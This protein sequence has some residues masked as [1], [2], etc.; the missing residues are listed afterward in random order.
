MRNDDI[1]QTI[2]D[3]HGARRVDN[4]NW[5]GDRTGA[6]FGCMDWQINQLVDAGLVAIEGWGIIQVRVAKGAETQSEAIPI[7]VV[8]TTDAA[9]ILDWD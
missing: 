3:E 1:L 8:A 9:E 4:H 5:R 6:V 2:I 7:E